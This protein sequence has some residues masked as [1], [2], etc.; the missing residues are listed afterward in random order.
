MSFSS[1]S[2]RYV[3]CAMVT[4]ALRGFGGV[5]SMST[6]NWRGPMMEHSWRRSSFLRTPVLGM[7]MVRSEKWYFVLINGTSE[8][9]GMGFMFLMVYESMKTMFLCQ[10]AGK[11]RRP[12][13]FAVFLTLVRTLGAVCCREVCGD[14]QL[15]HSLFAKAATKLHKM[16][17]T[18]K[19]DLALLNLT[20]VGM[21]FI[22]YL[23]AIGKR[24][25]NI[26]KQMVQKYLGR[27]CARGGLVS[28][29]FPTEVWKSVRV[30][31]RNFKMMQQIYNP[32]VHRF[33]DLIYVCMIC[34]YT[35]T[36][37]HIYIHVIYSCIYICILYVCD[38]RI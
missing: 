7:T 16:I 19:I 27:H 37:T 11:L 33:S 25:I 38:I 31:C 1:P 2:R 36:C 18:P 15:R 35:C 13:S 22:P 34:K 32:W 3:F 24:I 6:K 21:P 26:F 14:V 28:F 29:L 5:F 10:W 4:K 9:T 23:W 12:V 8:K 30:A 20:I 17:W